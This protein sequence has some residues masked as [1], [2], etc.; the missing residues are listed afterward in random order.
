MEPGAAAEGEASGAAGLYI[1][2]D[3]QIKYGGTKG[4]SARFGH[5]EV[6]SPEFRARFQE[7]V[8]NE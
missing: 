3:G 8:D 4:C 2:L 7:I 5:A 6:H 1:T